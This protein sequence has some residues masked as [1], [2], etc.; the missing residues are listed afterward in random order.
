M[1]DPYTRLYQEQVA[2]AYRDTR[3]RGP[4]DQP[5]AA[6]TKTNPLCGD[7]ITLYGRVIVVDDVKKLELRFDGRGCVLSQA[8]ASLVCQKACELS[9]Q[10]VAALEQKDILALIPLALGPSRM[11]CVLLAYHTLVELLSKLR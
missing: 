8:T 1:S 7:T 6:V 2:A 9:Y 5:D 11:Q 3:Y 4:M 10:Q